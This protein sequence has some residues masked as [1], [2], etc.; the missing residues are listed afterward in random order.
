MA[1]QISLTKF[2]LIFTG[3]LV[4]FGVALSGAEAG[5]WAQAA[6]SDASGVLD[7]RDARARWNSLSPDEK[8]RL[9]KR[10]E[11]LESMNESERAQLVA[12]ANKLKRQEERVLKSLSPEHRRRLTT[13]PPS[14]RKELLAEMVESERRERGVRIESK[15]PKKTR[16]W[17]R[18]SPPEERAKRLERFRELTRERISALAVE[19]LARSLGYGPEEVRRL[20]QLPIEDRTKTVMFLRRK[21][22]TKERS[23]GGTLKAFTTEMWSELEA[24][25]P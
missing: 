12:R 14:K 15:L 5:I 16:D 25:T 10:F 4:L 18:N 19:G 20:E 9:R 6:S 21:L 8:T 7:S 13:Q 22:D 11:R 24:L 23:V 17:L 1:V 2:T 3:W